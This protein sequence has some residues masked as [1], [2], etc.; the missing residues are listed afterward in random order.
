MNERNCSE[1]FKFLENA[2]KYESFS[3][4][5][6]IPNYGDPTSVDY[7]LVDGGIPIAIAPNS[8]FSA[9]TADFSSSIKKS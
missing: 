5:F 1:K 6:F 8:Q 3:T 4:S 7:Q 9:S 2:D